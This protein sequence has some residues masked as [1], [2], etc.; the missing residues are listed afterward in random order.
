MCSA[1]GFPASV[2]HWTDAGGKTPQERL[3]IRFRRVDTLVKFLGPLGLGV[4]DLGTLP[5]IQLFDAT[6]RQRHCAT[7]EDVWH[8]VAELTGR[9][10]DPLNINA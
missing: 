8:H 3:R 10:F 1:C 4:R 2:G 5:G 7:L 6:G 9:P